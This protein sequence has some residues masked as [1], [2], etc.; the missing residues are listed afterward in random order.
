MNSEFARAEMVISL[1]GA[2]FFILVIL[3]FA[4]K[5]G[6]LARFVASLHTESEEALQKQSADLL[7][8]MN[9]NVAENRARRASGLGTRSDAE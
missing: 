1:V 9:R 5:T 2:M 8:K 7:A 3:Y 4:W 6:W